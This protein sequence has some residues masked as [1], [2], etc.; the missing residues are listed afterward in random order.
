MI[1]ACHACAET[2]GDSAGN[3]E[4][5]QPHPGTLLSSRS[6]VSFRQSEEPLVTALK[7]QLL[8]QPTGLKR[9]VI[10]PP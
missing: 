4:V 3:A 9:L 6:G 5:T 2:G 1:C 8:S 10:T 7:P